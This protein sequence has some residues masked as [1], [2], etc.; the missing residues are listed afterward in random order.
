MRNVR[1]S[2]PEALNGPTVT[3]VREWARR[4]AFSSRTAA[5]GVAWGHERLGRYLWAAGHLEDRAA[6]F[7]A[8][9]G[10]LP[11]EVGPDA[12]VVWSTP[13]V[14]GSRRRAADSV[15][16]VSQKSESSTAPPAEYSIGVPGCG[17]DVPR[18]VTSQGCRDRSMRSEDGSVGHGGGS[19][20][21]NEVASES[22]SSS[23]RL[24]PRSSARSC[25]SPSRAARAE[26]SQ[27]SQQRVVE[28]GARN[29]DDTAQRVGAAGQ[30]DRLLV[31]VGGA[32]EQDAGF[33]RR[34]E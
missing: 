3:P 1:R 27:R 4:E 11:D 13:R 18:V 6:E 14:D 29:L 8:A 23:R 20:H 32:R 24:C 31:I 17:R 22:N 2:S 21:V 7:E 15:E 30:H 16:R 9:A 34:H 26:S 25:R 12:A 19:R 5:A 33:E 28:G 10:L